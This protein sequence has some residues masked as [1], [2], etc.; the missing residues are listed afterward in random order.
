MECPKKW[1]SGYQRNSICFVCEEGGG[2]GINF[3]RKFAYLQDNLDVC[4]LKCKLENTDWRQKISF[5]LL[6]L[7]IQ[8]P[9]LLH[10]SN[11]APTHRQQ[12]HSDMENKRIND[13]TVRTRQPFTVRYILE[14]C[15][16]MVKED[17]NKMRQGWNGFF[18]FFFLFNARNVMSW[19]YSL[20]TAFSNILQF[21]I[22]LCCVASNYTPTWPKRSEA[23]GVKIQN[24]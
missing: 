23:F 3:G 7:C 12:Q 17:K 19:V 15:V 2:G 18:S 10:I 4:P 8:V 14:S 22:P 13:H 5:F 21:G 11:L 24:V 1:S 20:T 6:N 9:P 16:S